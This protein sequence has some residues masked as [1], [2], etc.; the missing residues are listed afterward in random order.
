M[1]KEMDFVQFWAKKFKQ[2]PEKSRKLLNSFIN[3]QILRAQA[4]LKKLPPNKLIEIFKITNEK[5]IESL[6]AESQE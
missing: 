6:F 1:K 4:Q 2:N 3:N 5:I